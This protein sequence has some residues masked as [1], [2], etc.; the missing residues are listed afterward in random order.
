VFSTI[1][2]MQMANALE[3]RSTPDSLFAIRP[4]SNRLLVGAVATEALALLAFVYLPPL[5]RVLGHEALAVAQWIPALAGFVVL[6]SAEEARK[7]VV[8]SRLSRVPARPGSG[9]PSDPRPEAGEKAGLGYG[10]RP[11]DRDHRSYEVLR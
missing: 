1:V 11:R 4:F 5:R 8:R 10:D 7:G 3:C 9:G 2:A 6:L